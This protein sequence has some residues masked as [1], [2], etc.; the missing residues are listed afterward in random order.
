VKATS[1][2]LQKWTKV[3]RQCGLS[4]AHVQMARELGMNPKRALQPESP[5]Q[6]PLAGVSSSSTWNASGS[7]S[8]TQLRRCGSCCTTPAPGKEP[9]LTNGGARDAGLSWTTSK[10]CEHRC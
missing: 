7:L 1:D 4:D 5:G 6:E 10:P 9:K 2:E 3:K 8:P